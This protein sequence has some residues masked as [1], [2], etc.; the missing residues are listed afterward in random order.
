MRMRL[1]ASVCGQVKSE[2]MNDHVPLQAAA[3]TQAQSRHLRAYEQIGQ[4]ERG[5]QD[6]A[7]AILQADD[8]VATKN[9]K[10]L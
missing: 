8:A 7:E 6:N 10:R 4:S 5:K 2:C 3:S 9:N 1:R